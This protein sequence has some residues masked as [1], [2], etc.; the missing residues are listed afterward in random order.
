MTGGTQ[1]IGLLLP[2]LHWHG[3][4]QVGVTLAEAWARQGLDVDLA[5]MQTVSQPL[6]GRPTPSV[7]TRYLE[8]PSLHTAIVRTRRWA[9][10]RRLDVLLA[11]GDWASMTAGLAFVASRHR[12]RVIVGSEHFPVSAKFGDFRHYR[13]RALGLLMRY[14]YR[15][16]DAAVC[17]NRE[18]QSRM[19]SQLGWPPSRCP[20][21][22]NPVRLGLIDPQRALDLATERRRGG[23]Y[24]V[25]AAGALQ[26]RKD[27]ST[28]LRAF[29]EAADVLPLRLRIAGTGE[30]LQPLRAL[31]EELGISPRVE[32]LGTVEDMTSFLRSADVFAFSSTQEAFG[33]VLVEA[34][35]QAVPIV[36]TNCR[37]GP[38]EIIT[39]GVH[40]R[41]VPVGD[42]HAFAGALVEVLADPPSPQTLLA[43]AAEFEPAPVAATYVKLFNDL[44]H[45]PDPH[46]TR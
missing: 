19:V 42:A 39:D 35:S 37:S 15:N 44:L 12:P 16:L 29:A 28:L 34:L 20:V 9:S 46:H 6:Q 8:A 11:I 40:G 38:S 4:S 14:G 25:A 43:R 1:R 27:L 30:M 17:V 26:P 45:A 32:F 24:V 10:H 13:G 36:S 7:P 33:L 41:L 22:P 2:N 31:S 5:V 3:G 21:I 23:D 18:L